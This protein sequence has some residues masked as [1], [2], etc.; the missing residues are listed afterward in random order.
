MAAAVVDVTLFWG[1]KGGSGKTTSAVREFHRLT[2]K[3]PTDVC[4]LVDMTVCC[5]ATQRLLG[6]DWQEQ[7][8]KRHE[9]SDWFRSTRPRPCISFQPMSGPTSAA[10]WTPR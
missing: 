6:S 10:Y 8:S 4:V 3:H 2:R 1:R 9:Y 7:V 5:S